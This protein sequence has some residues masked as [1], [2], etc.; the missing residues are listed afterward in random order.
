MAVCGGLFAADEKCVR[1]GD[2]RRKSATSIA[3]ADID[4]LNKVYALHSL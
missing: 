2:S 4:C 1:D 3:D